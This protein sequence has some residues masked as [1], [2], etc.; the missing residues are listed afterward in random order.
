MSKLNSVF[1]ATSLDGFIADE[2]G[3]IDFLDSIENPEG[4][5]MG[6]LEFMS[7]IQALVMGRK[8]FEKVLSFGIEWPYDKPVFV[9]SNSLKSIPK[10]LENKVSL[11]NGEIDSILKSIHQKGYDRLYIDGGQLIQS[12]LKRDLIDEIIIS[13]IPKLLGKGI[14]LFSKQENQVDFN[15]VS[16]T[17]FLDSIVQNRFLRKGKVMS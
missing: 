8:T 1:I 16:S 3:G 4:D 10:N 11:L 7:R 17:I 13:I 15:C 5:D 14:P 12:F 6:Y 2:K 9:L